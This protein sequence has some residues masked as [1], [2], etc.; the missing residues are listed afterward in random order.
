MHAGMNEELETC[1]HKESE[2]C[3]MINIFYSDNNNN[4]DD[5]NCIERCNSRF[6]YNLLT[7]PRT[8]SNMQALVAW[9]WSCASHVQHIER[10]S[11]ATCHV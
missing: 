1:F 9:A 8:V 11:R 6:F 5:N 3:W 7:A 4:N 2:I 10:L